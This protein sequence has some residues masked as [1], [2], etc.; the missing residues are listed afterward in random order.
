MAKIW[1]LCEGM[2]FARIIEVVDLEVQLDLMVVVQSVT[3]NNIDSVKGWS[4][5]NKIK[6]LLE[7]NWSVRTVY[8]F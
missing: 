3:T 1:S 5:M 4:L 6:E 8:I 7:L 2:C